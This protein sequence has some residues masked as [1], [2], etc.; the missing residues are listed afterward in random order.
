MSN[1][2]YYRFF[3]LLTALVSFLL[4]SLAMAAPDEGRDGSEKQTAVFQSWTFVGKA[5]N[6]ADELYYYYF[7]LQ[8]QGQWTTVQALLLKDRS[9]SYLHYYHSEETTQAQHEHSFRV[10]KTFMR[11]NP[12]SNSWIF[13]LKTSEEQSFNFRVELLQQ[14]DMTQKKKSL[15]KDIDLIMLAPKQMNG[16][17]RFDDHKKEEFVTARENWYRHIRREGQSN[18]NPLIEGVF[19]FFDDQSR[20][21]ALSVPLERAQSASEVVWLNAKGAPINVS[22]FIQLKERGEDSLIL[23]LAVPARRF[24]LSHLLTGSENQPD[25]KAGFIERKNKRAGFCFIDTV[26]LTPQPGVIPLSPTP[27]PQDPQAGWHQG[28]IIAV[29]DF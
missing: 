6:E 11:F 5:R 9:P 13:G 15:A 23:S 14:S 18:T 27:K 22:Q 26:G 4:S 21:Y 2:N 8:Q 3:Y 19:C 24:T 7:Q 12:I 17:V 20:L 16:H 1:S 29:R 28:A 10:G 25:L